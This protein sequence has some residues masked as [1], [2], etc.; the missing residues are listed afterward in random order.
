MI[1]FDTNTGYWFI[2]AD[3]TQV[4]SAI[5]A[6]LIPV[7]DPGYQQWSQTFETGQVDTIQTIQKFLTQ[8]GVPPYLPITQL[9]MRRTLRAAGLLPQVQAA[10]QQADPDT[11]DAWNYAQ[12][13]S[14]LDPIITTLSTALN[15]PWAQVIQLFKQAAVIPEPTQS[16]TVPS[17]G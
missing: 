5:T 9:Q 15:I 8:Q 3:Q 4:F 17:T 13:I 10:I 16:V 6:G 11:Q 2:G 14:I 1:Q 12:T 7:S